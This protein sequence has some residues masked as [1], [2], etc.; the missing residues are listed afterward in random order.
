MLAVTLVNTRISA[1]TLAISAK[2]WNGERSWMEQSCLHHH[3]QSQEMP[4]FINDLPISGH[5]P[6][7]DLPILAVLA[8]LAKG[9]QTNGTQGARAEWAK[10]CAGFIASCG[11]CQFHIST[12]PAG[13]AY[14]DGIPVCRWGD[15]LMMAEQTI[16]ET[17]SNIGEPAQWYQIVL[18]GKKYGKRAARVPRMA[19]SGAPCE[20]T[21]SSGFEVAGL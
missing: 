6:Q 14:P 9:W 2:R 5:V 10:G 1:F 13:A 16:R 19:R 21:P 8:G 11:V 4:M 17:G 20:M 3:K 12:A 7:T 15:E 18:I